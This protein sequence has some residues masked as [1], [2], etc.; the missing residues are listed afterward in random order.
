MVNEKP[1]PQALGHGISN[2]QKE[3]RVV[4]IEL[5]ASKNII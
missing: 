1:R 3:Y 4:W 5:G 2:E